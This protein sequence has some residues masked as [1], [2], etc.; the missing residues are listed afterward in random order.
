[1]LLIVTSKSLTTCY[2]LNGFSCGASRGWRVDETVGRRQVLSGRQRQAELPG[3]A[4]SFAEQR[5]EGSPG[6][7]HILNDSPPLKRSGFSQ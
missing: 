1:M 3:A 2:L 4:A 6:T 5:L 7:F